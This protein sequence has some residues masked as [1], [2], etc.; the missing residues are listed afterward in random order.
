MWHEPEKVA[1]WVGEIMQG[2]NEGWIQPFVDKAF[3][4]DQAGE[5]HRYMEERK[6]TGKVVLVP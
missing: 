5:A 1:E 2:I 3:P 4:F 6:N